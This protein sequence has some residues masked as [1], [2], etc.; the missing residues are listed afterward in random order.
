[1]M[2]QFATLFEMMQV[3]GDE[4]KCIDHLR[5]IRWAGGAYCPYCGSGRV[6]HF[7]DNRTHKCGDCR[8]RFSIKVGTIFEDTKIPLTKWFMAIWQS[9]V[10]ALPRLGSKPRHLR[11]AFSN[12][13]AARSSASERSRVR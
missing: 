1:M 6:Y 5:A 7:K 3:F 13:S 9:Q 10:R 11:R 12:V 8:Q 2:Q 4:Q